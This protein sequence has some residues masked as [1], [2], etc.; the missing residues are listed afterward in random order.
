MSDIETLDQILAEA[1]RIRKVMTEQPGR[2]ERG[3]ALMTEA[4]KKVDRGP[5]AALSL[6]SEARSEIEQE[7]VVLR[8]LA[9]VNRRRKALPSYVPTD[10]EITI[11]AQ[12]E[13]VLRQGEYSLAGQ[14]IKRLEEALHDDVD[15]SVENEV[16]LELAESEI[17]FGRGNTL[18]AKMR[19]GSKFPIR[20]LKLVG[21]STQAQVIVFDEYKGAIAPGASKDV[22]VNIIPNI[23]GD[24]V[25]EMEGTV[26]MSSRQVP[27]KRHVSM[28]VLPAPVP[29]YTVQGPQP[30]VQTSRTPTV[31]FDPLALVDTGTVDQWTAC[32]ITYFESRGTLSLEGLVQKKAGFQTA[33]GYR[34]LYQSLLLM[35]Y[36]RSTDWHNWFDLQGFIGDDMTRRCADL[37]FHLR[38]SPGQFEI[39]LDGNVGSSN[40]Q[41]LISA[42][43]IASGLILLERD[44]RKDIMSWEINGI[45]N[46]HPFLVRV[47]RSVKKGEGGAKSRSI[48]RL[49]L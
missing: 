12:M 45:K 25:V 32:I 15:M 4:G 24:V 48:F 49:T 33:E 14:N 2:Y 36:P 7:A 8:R 21:A 39:E 30:S 42:L 47:E 44:K 9:E 26:E 35:D 41:Y 23:E 34:A 18:I 20:L 1:V 46:G 3:K 6:M 13:E 38:T 16:R 29:T 28:K 22:R 27:M 17:T 5:K 19:N 37:L 31:V 10:E 43:H 11:D 40:N